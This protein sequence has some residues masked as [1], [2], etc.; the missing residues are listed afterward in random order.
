M[1][2]SARDD[3]VIFPYI[4]HRRGRRPRRPAQQKRPCSFEQSLLN[5]LV[6]RLHCG[7]IYSPNFTTLRW[8]S[9]SFICNGFPSLNSSYSFREHCKFVVNLLSMQNNCCQTFA[10]RTL[11]KRYPVL[12]GFQMFPVSCFLL[13]RHKRPSLLQCFDGP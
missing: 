7:E 13:P 10:L 1:T 4:P 9:S 5:I 8:P 11:P 12:I 3:V 2:T 6:Q